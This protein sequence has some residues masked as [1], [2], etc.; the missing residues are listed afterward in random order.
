MNGAER[1]EH[2][3]VPLVLRV[4][5]PDRG[6]A[7][8]A[9]ENLSDGGLFV[10]TSEPLELGEPVT[11][12]LSFPGL[13]DPIQL[14]GRVAWKRSG[15]GGREPGV[16]VAVEA[17][18]ER[19][20]L[21]T[22]VSAREPPLAS[23][24]LEREG[25]RVLIVED[26]PHIIEMYSYVLKKLAS[27]ELGGKVPIEVHFSPDGHHALRLLQEGRF[28]LV[29]TDLYMPV[30]DGFALVE[31][32]RQTE[33]LRSVPVVVITAGGKDAQERAMQLG[34]DIF[35]RK[36]VK[37]AEVLETVKGLLKLR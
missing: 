34:V 9:T 13:L 14:S 27:Q 24:Q 28:N 17:E 11:L 1:R 8:G 30:M 7:V 31:R 3:R 23:A 4:G 26:N 15:E 18:A 19:L 35:L 12:V 36:P 16:G 25:Y 33:S 29:M 2:S 22:L 21:R 5:F 6:Q 20:R 37:F 10:Q 32:I